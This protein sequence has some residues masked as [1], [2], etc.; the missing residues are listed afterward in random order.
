LRV[1]LWNDT[2]KKAMMNRDPSRQNKTIQPG[3]GKGLSG[4]GC[5]CIMG[6]SFESSFVWVDICAV[7]VAFAVV[8]GRAAV[9]IFGVVSGAVTGALVKTGRQTP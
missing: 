2:N 7:V 8:T 4:C 1:R 9:V 6:S 3:W 5:T